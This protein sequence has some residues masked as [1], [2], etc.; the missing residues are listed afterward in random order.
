M[1]FRFLRSFDR[2]FKCLPNRRR[3]DARAAIDSLLDFHETGRRTEGLGLKKLRKD[4]WEIR[5]DIATRIL[6]TMNDAC[7]TFVIV[8]NHDEIQRFLK[9]A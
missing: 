5:S 3:E 7:V 8:G 6:F 1:T 4:F 2:A 9:D